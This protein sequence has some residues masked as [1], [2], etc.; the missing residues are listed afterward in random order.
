MINAVCNIFRCNK[1]VN[2]VKKLIFHIREKKLESSKS[3]ENFIKTIQ[4][5]RRYK[6]VKLAFQSIKPASTIKTFSTKVE[7]YLVKN[8]FAFYLFT[9]HILDMDLIFP[10]RHLLYLNTIFI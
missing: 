4:R 5:L 10:L 6:W 7:K 3:F 9:S 8:I 1:S 2:N